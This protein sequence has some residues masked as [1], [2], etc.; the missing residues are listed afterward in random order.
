MGENLEQN[1]L[2]LWKSMKNECVI[3][4]KSKVGYEM[5]GK[6]LDLNFLKFAWQSFFFKDLTGIGEKRQTKFEH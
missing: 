1:E 2:N 6:L 4:Q 3:P 5:I